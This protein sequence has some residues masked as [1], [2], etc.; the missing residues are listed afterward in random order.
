MPAQGAQ[1][2]EG[3]A[4]ILPDPAIAIAIVRRPDYAN[5]F[6]ALSHLGLSREPSLRSTAVRWLAKGWQILNRKALVFLRLAS[7]RLMPRKLGKPT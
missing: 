6:V 1:C 4:N 3:L 5:G 2:R 7:I